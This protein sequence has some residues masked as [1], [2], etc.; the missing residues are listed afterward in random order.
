MFLFPVSLG[1]QVSLHGLQK[2]LLKVRKAPNGLTR[3]N[4]MHLELHREV[5][6]ASGRS[7]MVGCLPT[8]N[9][10]TISSAGRGAV[11]PAIVPIA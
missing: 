7:L 11:S 6:S 2:S 8:G 1:S 9:H 4:K 3:H 5:L 10:G